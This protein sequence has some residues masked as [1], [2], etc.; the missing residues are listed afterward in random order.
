MS[1]SPDQIILTPEQ[2]V[3]LARL[4][5]QTGRAWNEV[6]A[7]ALSLLDHNNRPQVA[8]VESVYEALVRLGLLGSIKGAP[9]DLSTNPKYMEGFGERDD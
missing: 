1:T 8:N 5:D 4:A 9:P 3:Q 6:L 2:R 7:E